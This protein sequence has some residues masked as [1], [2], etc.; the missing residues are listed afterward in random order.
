MSAEK[1]QDWRA[2]KHIYYL[3]KFEGKKSISFRDTSRWAG[4]AEGRDKQKGNSI[5]VRCSFRFTGEYTEA[6]GVKQTPEPAHESNGTL[7]D[8]P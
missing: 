8:V 5:L 7:S 3:L 4:G 1:K 2:N 6:A